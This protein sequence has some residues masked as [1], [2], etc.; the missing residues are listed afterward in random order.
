MLIPLVI[1]AVCSVLLGFIGTPLW[2]WF[3]TFL[4]KEPSIEGGVAMVMLTSSVVALAGI[5]AG[6]WLYGR[7]PMARSEEPDVLEQRWP[8]VFGLLRRKYYVDEV[9][10]WAF[11]GLNAAWAKACDWLDRWVWSGAVRLVSYAILGLS[12]VNRVFDEYVI[13]LGFDR[14]CRGLTDGG[15]LMS[16][17]QSGK[18]QNYLRVIGLGLVIL[19]LFLIWGCRGS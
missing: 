18:V 19:A 17:W 1:L 5:G 8:D 15:G 12:W 9:Y 11:V 7:K 2:P 4:G 14:S 10:D 6:W 3:H 13:N 16:R